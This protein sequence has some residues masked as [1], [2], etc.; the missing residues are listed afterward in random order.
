[1]APADY[2]DAFRDELS[3]QTQP[4]NLPKL[5]VPAIITGLA[6]AFARRWF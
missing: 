5:V 2:V 4:E 3:E 1:M 6:V